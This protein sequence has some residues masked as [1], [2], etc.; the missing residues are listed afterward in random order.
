[1]SDWLVATLLLMLSNLFMTAAWYGHL[2]FTRAPITLAPD[3]DASR[4]ETS[5][6]FVVRRRGYSHV[7]RGIVQENSE[8]YS[9]TRC[10]TARFGSVSE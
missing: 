9:V 10:G 6:T 1:M 4:Y 5:H 2:R 7:L 8:T 3:A